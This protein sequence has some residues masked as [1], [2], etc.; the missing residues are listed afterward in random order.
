MANKNRAGNAFMNWKK[1]EDRLI[2]KISDRDKKSQNL[3][4]VDY[5]YNNYKM[6]EDGSKVWS[7]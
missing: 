5:T 1:R 7:F 4:N 3:E 2:E 6:S